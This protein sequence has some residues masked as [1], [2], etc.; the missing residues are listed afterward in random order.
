MVTV[1]FAP[2]IQRHKAVLSQQLPA[3]TL[4]QV[5]DTAC[6]A[7]EGLRHYILDDQGAIRKHVAVFIN[8][9]MHQPRDDLS[10]VLQSGDKV[11]V[12]QCLTGG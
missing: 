9:D 7:S 11:L 6:A 10:R 12:I 2:S 4:A 5:L 3:N 1:D 8:R